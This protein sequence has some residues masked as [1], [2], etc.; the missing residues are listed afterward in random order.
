MDT[1]IVHRCLAYQNAGFIVFTFLHFSK[2]S[3]SC[4]DMQLLQKSLIN[5]KY[6]K[7]KNASNLL[8]DFLITIGNIYL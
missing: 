7:Q 2:N 1:K 4:K 8:V 3:F 6:F 5:I